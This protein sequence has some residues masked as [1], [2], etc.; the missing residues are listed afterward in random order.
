[1]KRFFLT[2]SVI[3]C[4]C[5]TALLHAQVITT[6]PLFPIDTDSVTVIFDAAQGSQGLMNLNPPVVYAHTGVITNLSTSGSD[7]KYV[8]AGW[9]ENLPKALMTSMG[10]NKYKLTLKPSIRSYYGVPASEQILKMAFVFR[11]SD[12]SKTGKN[13]NGS[14]IFSDVY[15]AK[16]SVNIVLPAG[17]AL[18]LK[19]NDPIRIA[20]ISPLADSLKLFVNGTLV[21]SV[22][23]QNIADTLYADNFGQN[24][25]KQWIR[26]LA[27][28]DTAS[29][30]DS[31]SY[32][33]I[34][35]AV[36]A[37]LPPGVED[38]INYIDSTTVVLSLYA[39]YK[40]N[41]FVIGDFNNWQID[42]NYYTKI[43]PAGNRYWL[44]INNLIPRQEYIF[45]YL[46]DGNLRI[47]DPYADKVSD[48]N[49][50]YISNTTYPGLRPYP[51][52][53]TNGI[54]TY[55]QTGQR[56][57][58]WNEMLFTPP[59]VTDL[60]VYELLIRDFTTAHDYPSLID[61]LGYLKNLGINAI[62]LM[63][64]MEF[65]GNISW[66]YNPDFSFAPDK[67]YGTKN[68]LKQF[69][70]AAHAMGIA[71]IL[72]IVCNQ[73]FGSSPLVRL[74][75]NADAQQPAANNPWFNQVATHPY[76]VGY[77]FNHE[78][79]ATRTYIERL[80]RYWL[81]EYHVDGYRFDLSKGFTEFNSGSDVALWG[82]YDASR[83][84]ILN[85]YESVLHAVKP[86]AYMILE[87][88]ADNSEETVLSNHN[89][90]IWGN[91][92]GA[93]GQASMGWTTGSTS[94]L[95]WASYKNR[96]WS[97]PNLV[98]YM[99]SHDE[100]RIMFKNIANGNTTQPQYIIKGD[101]TRGLKRAELSANFFFTIPGPK[102]I[103]QFEELGYDY[104]I[105]YGGNRVDPKPI[106]WDYLDQW[107]R[108]YTKNVFSALINL[109]K[110]QP[111]FA[112]TNYTMDVVGAVK[113]IWLQ[114]STMDATVLGNF[115]I[116]AQNVNPNFT[117]TGIWYEFYTGDSL[118]VVNTTAAIPMK[119]GEYRLYTSVK[120]QKPVFTGI[121]DNTLPEVLNG[122]HVRVYPNPSD[123]LFNF[124]LNLPQPS[125]AEITIFN[126][127]GQIVHK[128]VVNDLQQGLNTFSMDLSAGKTAKISAGIYVY[129]LDAGTIHEN[130]KLL[131]E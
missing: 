71:V 53:Q 65:E 103:W 25:V 81:M 75:W 131:V 18:Y 86:G 33:V 60:V 111:V 82:H 100:E 28:N 16:T 59:A 34:P 7:W 87:H 5:I 39:P 47:G 92:T 63:P 67:Y 125:P 38:G 11:N 12:G 21:K 99:E 17:K 40:N 94:D 29:A 112:T 1:M 23:G 15:P 77:D 24:W 122:S 91:I 85:N 129:R 32:T 116:V 102:M 88:F 101:T 70:E 109:K 48:P 74:Y 96:G 126:M 20:A 120:L 124:I 68:G 4:G 95:S 114:H 13:A 62:E 121:D 57:Y 123:G 2:T 127:F 35:P 44:Q 3:L 118:S 51:A 83:I 22:A 89:M 27:K 46:V 64:I 105:T 14:D 42:S 50:Q 43:T 78:N 84:A 45:Q 110:T 9:S 6:T 90:L 56:P 69:V 128:S 37:D 117:K 54:A 107:R 26:I 104:P 52:A 79:P 115:D 106:R 31:F 41:V 36:V 93:Y 72:D 30:A 80:I 55:L 8:V 97:Q 49:D 73:H 113:R 61:T 76:S 98:D 108:R 58:Q 19:Q 119:A 130:G 10:N 66:G